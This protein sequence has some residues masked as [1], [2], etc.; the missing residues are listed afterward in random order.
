MCVRA[1]VHHLHPSSAARERCTKPPMTDLPAGFSGPPRAVFRQAEAAMKRRRARPPDMHGAVAI[2]LA[3]ALCGDTPP[4]GAD[5]AGQAIASAVAA[6][7]ISFLFRNEPAYHNQYHQAEATIAMGWL[8]ATARR[9]DLLGPAAAAAAVLAMAG[10]DLLHDGSIASPGTLEAH[11][12]DRTTALAARA[13]LD[14]AALATI[15]RVILATDPARSSAERDADDLLCRLA[16]EAD[17]F[18]SLTPQLGWRLSQALAREV[19]AAGFHPD[20][21]FDS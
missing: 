14:A 20:P 19:R 16:Q 3:E 2:A 1:H 15:R 9:L 6:H 4:P 7:A 5:A 11:A 10:H 18:D 21:P 13:G 8:C 12:A 17:L